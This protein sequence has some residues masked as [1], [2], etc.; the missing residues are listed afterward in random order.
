MKDSILT[1]A[2]LEVLLGSGQEE[3]GPESG[4]PS[5]ALDLGESEIGL[6]DAIGRLPCPVIGLGKGPLASCCDV[7]LDDAALLAR[8]QANIRVAPL[9]SMIL[10]QLLRMAQSLDYSAALMAESFAYAAVQHGPEFRRWQQLCSDHASPKPQEHGPALLADRVGDRMMIRLNRPLDRNAIGTDMRDALV[11][12]LDLAVLDRDI[13]QIELSGIGRCFSTGGDVRE[14]GTIGDPATAHW[15]RTLRLPA[16]RLPKLSE[17]LVVRVHGAVVGAGL[18][19]AA[20]AGQ[21]IAKPNSWFQ[22]PELKYGLI[23][24][25]GGTVSIRQRIGRQRTALLALSMKKLSVR[26]AKAWGLVDYIDD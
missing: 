11:E 19:L 22:L 14:F 12:V 3:F 21:I 17:R 20:F 6:S 8:V 25:A 18:E 5:V 4:Y 26:Q 1:G 15:I 16:G 24:G 2:A 23:P 10:V 13:I 7:V 9:A